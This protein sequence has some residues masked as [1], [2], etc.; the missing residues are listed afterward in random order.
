LNLSL[1]KRNIVLT[2]GGCFYPLHKNH[3]KV[4]EMGKKLIEE[5]KDEFNL[6]GCFLVL[7]H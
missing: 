1:D 2:L 4:I 6:I 5:K 3:I 7:S